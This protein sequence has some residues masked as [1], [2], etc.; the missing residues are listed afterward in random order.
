MQKLKLS[1]THNT[2]MLERFYPWILLLTIMALVWLLAQAFWLVF[3]PPKAPKLMP[4]PLQANQSMQN[5][6]ANALDIFA[7]PQAMQAQAAPPPDIK[8][9]GVTVAVPERFSYAII[10]ANGKTKNYRVHDTIEGSN[11]VLTEVKRDFIMVS[12]GG[13]QPTKIQFGQ[14]FSLDQ[15]EAIRAKMAAEQGG[16]TMN[17]MGMNPNMNNTGNTNNASP[18]TGITGNPFMPSSSNSGAMISNGDNG[19][20]SNPAAP[21]NSSQTNNQNSGGAKAAIGGAVSGLQQN[22][23]GYLSQMGV[24]AT[25]QGYLVTDGMPA[26]LK[27][28][29]GLQTGDKVLSVNGQSVGSNPSQDAQLLQQVQQSGQAQIQVQRGDQTVTVRQSF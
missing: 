11:Y 24:A 13:G 28:R 1:A 26:G 14:P 29:L 27:N 2:A 21:Q 3:A 15:S 20:S 10:S 18:S 19:N 8:V 6:T 9:L 4:V 5:N 23:A 25:G 17:G 7:Q 12:N 22:P 16:N